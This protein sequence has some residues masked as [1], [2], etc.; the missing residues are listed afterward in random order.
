MKSTWNFKQMEIFITS[1]LHV[2]ETVIRNFSISPYSNDEDNSPEEPKH[3]YVRPLKFSVKG[4]AHKTSKSNKEHG[5]KS[6]SKKY[7][8]KKAYRALTTEKA[9]RNDSMRSYGNEAHDTTILARLQTIEDRVPELPSC[10]NKKSGGS[11]LGDGSGKH[12]TMSKL[13]MVLKISSKFELRHFCR[14][15]GSV[16]MAQGEDLKYWVSLPDASK[17]DER[18]IPWPI[19]SGDSVAQHILHTIEWN[20]IAVEEEE[21]HEGNVE[22][23]ELNEMGKRV[24]A[25]KAKLRTINDGALS[26]SAY[27][28]AWVAM[29][30]GVQGN[31]APQFPSSIQWIAKN[32]LPD[33]SWGDRDFFSPYDR[34]INTL[35]CVVALKSWDLYPEK[36][37]KGLSFLRQNLHKLRDENPEHMPSGFEVR[38]PS[39][40]EMARKLGLEVP[41]NSPVLQDLHERREQKLKRIPRETLHSKPT[42]LL[43]S[44]EG[45]PGLDWEKLLKLQHPNGSFLC[46]PASTAYAFEHTKDKKC[47][48]YLENIVKGFNGGVP[49]TYPNDIFERLWIV[50]RLERLGISRYFKSEIKEFLDYV[51]RYWTPNGVSWSRDTIEL[52]IDDTSMAFRALR[53]HGYNVNADAF[54]HFERGGE[55]F[56]FVGQSSQGVTEMLSLYRASQ[57]LFPGE[58]T[59]QEAREFTY[60]FLKTKLASG[61]MADRWIITKDL[62]VEVQCYLEVPFHASL[63]RIETRYYID[64]YGGDDDVWIGKVLYRMYNVSNSLYLELAKSDYNRCQKLHQLEWIDIQRWYNDCNLKESGLSNVELLKANFVAMSSIFEPERATERLAWTRTMALIEAVTFYFYD[65]V[66]TPEKRSSF[67]ASFR[68]NTLYERPRAMNIK[69]R[70]VK[71]ILKTLQIISTEWESWLLKWRNVDDDMRSIPT[72]EAELLVNT[73]NMCSSVPFSENLMLQPAYVHLTRLVN[74]LCYNLRCLRSFK[75]SWKEDCD[76]EIGIRLN[77][78][79]E[80]QMQELLKCVVQSNDGLESN[81]KQS[82]IAVAKSF[83]YTTFIETKTMILHINK[84]LFDR[85]V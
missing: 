6:S 80:S 2:V 48:K 69:H 59:L 72:D 20:D 66:K 60:K 3:E 53:L 24:E 27:D 25:V 15:I 35:A 85:V 52:D 31:N 34:L 11:D 43:F 84:V 37:K 7:G 21:Q 54:K 42:T 17:V 19:Y 51:Y 50:D 23:F 76:G 28:T 79:I 39:L 45:M 44:L 61:Q 10:W 41:S 40:I 77:K 13:L 4:Y 36:C 55:F 22:V 12:A 1:V 57:V 65:E 38:F 63:P 9:E 64:Q 56:C 71:A 81:V 49:H 83:Y 14:T 73:I 78:T 18:L 46:S 30:K 16:A 5:K 68:T 82:F 62:G 70:L 75:D 29:V 33:G 32:Q 58:K 26:I 8:K 74:K 67:L 47:L